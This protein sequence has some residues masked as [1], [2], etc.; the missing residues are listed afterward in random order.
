[1]ALSLTALGPATIGPD[2]VEIPVVG[3]SLV[4]LVT[5]DDARRLADGCR[6]GARLQVALVDAGDGWWLARAARVGG[7][8]GDTR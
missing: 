6:A 2:S 5:G 1:M 3:G 4:V 7:G 8:F